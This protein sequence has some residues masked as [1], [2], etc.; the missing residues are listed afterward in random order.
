VT[1]YWEGV[2][3]CVEQRNFAGPEIIFP[4]VF[5][6]SS[7]KLFFIETRLVKTSFKKRQT[8]IKC[9]NFNKNVKILVKII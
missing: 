2:K 9:P 5:S 6:S 8:I 3:D 1:G 7:P 4:S